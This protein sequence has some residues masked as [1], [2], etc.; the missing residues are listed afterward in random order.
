MELKI[1]DYIAFGVRHVWSID[2]R[3]KKGVELHE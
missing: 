2:S 1:D 3:R